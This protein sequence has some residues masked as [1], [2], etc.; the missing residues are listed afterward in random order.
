MVSQESLDIQPFAMVAD[1]AEELCMLPVVATYGWMKRAARCVSRISTEAT[2]TLAL[3]Q[4]VDGRWIVPR[5]FYASI[6]SGRLTAATGIVDALV[7]DLNT[8]QVRSHLDSS[9]L[10]SPILARTAMAGNRAWIASRMMLPDRLH[11]TRMTMLYPLTDGEI[12]RVLCVDLLLPQGQGRFGSNAFLT[13]E[14]TMP[15]LGR[16]VAKTFT[17]VEHTVELSPREGEVLKLLQQGMT[18]KQIARELQRSPHTVHDHV[19]SLH[20]KVG[21]CN[22]GELLAKTFGL[23]EAHG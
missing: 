3:A 14:A 5:D 12:H 10:G 2:T 21:A 8:E 18:V 4:E 17:D 9:Q 20:R 15:I 7:A 1:M 13:L 22:R 6:G 23:F 11:P 19:K 16:R